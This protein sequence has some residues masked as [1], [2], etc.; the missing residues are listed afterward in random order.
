MQLDSWS[1]E[2]PFDIQSDSE[3]KIETTGDLCYAYPESGTGNATV[4]LCIVDNDDDMSRTG[5]LRVIFPKDSSKNKTY[6]LKQMCVA[7]YGENS[8]TI[9]SGNRIYAVGYGYNANAGYASVDAVKKPILRFAKAA[10]D[11]VIVIGSGSSTFEIQTYTGSSISKISNDLSTKAHLSGNVGGFTGEIK[12]SFDDKTFSSNNYEYALTYIDMA[13]EYLYCDANLEE[14]RDSA[15]YMTAAAYKAINGLSKTYAGKAGIKKVLQDYGTHMVVR[16]KMGGRL[17]YS[18][19]LDISK[20]TS[21]YDITAFA[22]ASYKSKVGNLDTGASVDETYKK[23]YEQNASKCNKKLAV[24]GGDRTLATKLSRDFS[25]ENLNAWSES[26]TTENMA[27]VGF[28]DANESL[29]PLYELVD[30]EKYP[31][32]YAEFKAYMEGQEIAQDFPT[33]AMTYDCG[34]AAKITIPEFG[35]DSVASLIKEVSVDGQAVAEICEEYIPVINKNERVKVVYPVLNNRTY[36]NMGYFLGDES[37]QPARVSWVDNDLTITTYSEEAYGANDVIYIK[38]SNIT[39]SAPDGKVFDGTVK[40]KTMKGLWGGTEVYEY[41]LVKI[42]NHVWTRMDY[43]GIT[44]SDGTEIAGRLASGGSFNYPYEDS[45]VAVYKNG[46]TTKYYYSRS[47]AALEQLAPAGWRVASSADYQSVKSTLG[48]NGFSLP[49]LALN[50]E[51]VTGFNVDYS[52]WCVGDVVNEGRFHYYFYEYRNSYPEG[53]KADY[54]TSDSCHVLFQ[55]SGVMTIE[56]INDDYAL[57]I[58]LIQE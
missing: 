52:G 41:P 37:H 45:R 48:S 24:L 17:T 26:L 46:D 8:V 39:S 11:E 49:A 30:E 43:Q 35:T 1:Y 42:F 31:Q 55:K 15:E 12:A 44:C 34:T 40:D 51:G 47:A 58:R 53:M 33:I 54:H 29:I 7:D 10:E 19:W 5:E 57:S 36:Y 25:E 20:V 21:A 56:A 18:M 32:R 2:I 22:E 13:I 23:S 4:K 28:S 27:L 9:N 50:P 16:S 38:G 3:W 6:Q 14:M